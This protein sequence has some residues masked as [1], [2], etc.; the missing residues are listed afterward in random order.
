MALA[1]TAE[2][3]FKIDVLLCDSVVVESGK[4]YI[5]GGGWNMLTVPGFPVS[6]PRIGV[7]AMIHVPYVQTNALH[8]LMITL[9]GSDGEELSLHPE[10]SGPLRLEAQFNI[11]RPATLAHGDEQVIPFAANLDAAQID[12]PGVY[13]F[14]FS[15]D[16]AERARTTF[17]VHGPQGIQFNT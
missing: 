10:A 14:V 1:T 12:G 2:I 4:L 6:I 7:G 5:Q 11:G 8:R 9:Q 3:D 15:I 16:D 13:T 17:R